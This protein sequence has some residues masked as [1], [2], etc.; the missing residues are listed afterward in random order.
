[1]N[2]SVTRATGDTAGPLLPQLHSLYRSRGYRPFRMSKFEKYE[3][4]A[5][6]KDF[7]VSDRVLTFTDTDGELLALKP[8]VTLSI[9]RAVPY[10]P[11]ITERL[12]YHENV[13][14]PGPPDGRFREMP[15]SGIECIGDL[16]SLAVYEVLA[17]ADESLR[18]LPCET[19]LA[20]SHLGILQQ[21]LNRL[22]A[23]ENERDEILRLVA[24]RSV[25][26]LA[27]LFEAHAYP[28]S[29]LRTL[30]TLLSLDCGLAELPDELRALDDHF[31]D[32]GVIAELDE[33]A[34]LAKGDGCRAR[35]DF[36]V[37]NDTH[38][39]NGLVFRGYAKGLSDKVLSGGRYDRLLRRM[40][41]PGGAVGFAIYLGLLS[42]FESDHDSLPDADVLVLYNGNTP[43]TLV[44]D[45]CARLRSEGKRVYT[46]RR[47][48][49][50]LR[51]A[52]VLD[53][54]KGGDSYA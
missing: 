23:D 1:M 22:P 31:A 18:L 11:G 17:M 3:L 21:L 32:P 6:C 53:L 25:H 28:D 48:D 2:A 8:D 49:E 7:L 13:Y 39:Y 46:Q 4:Y 47:M 29:V 9:L 45:T 35:F 12:F 52:E 24:A 27:A 5:A 54:T 16:D 38:Y 19:A 34:A 40:K 26:G 50:S 33:L 30:S 20:F 14:R 42:A 37:L 44:R 36:S 10:L 41:R 51:F 15:Q 43:F